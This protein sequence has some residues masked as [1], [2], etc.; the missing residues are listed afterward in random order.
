MSPKFDH[1]VHDRVR[2]LEL[3]RP[4]IVK[5]IYVCETGI[6]YQVRY[7]DNAKALTEYFYV[8]EIEAV[9]P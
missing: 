8:E 2:I 9:S 7:F 4:G 1:N 6:Q 5:G 3:E